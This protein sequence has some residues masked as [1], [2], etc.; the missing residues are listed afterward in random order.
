MSRSARIT[1]G[2]AL[3]GNLGAMCSY[4]HEAYRLGPNANWLVPWRP[5]EGLDLPEPSPIALVVRADETLKFF[6]IES[7]GD[8]GMETLQE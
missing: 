4:Q 3:N 2:Q 5:K 8:I 7:P 6:L 1:S